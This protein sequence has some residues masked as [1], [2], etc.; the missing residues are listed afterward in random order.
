[1][2]EYADDSSRRPKVKRV[3]I[4]TDNSYCI[5]VRNLVGKIPDFFIPISDFSRLKVVG[6]KCMLGIWVTFV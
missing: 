6:K 3:F 1:M 2:S 4:N 5:L